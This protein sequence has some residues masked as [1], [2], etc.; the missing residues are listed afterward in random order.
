MSAPSPVPLD[1]RAVARVLIEIAMLLELKGDNPFKI[2]AYRNGADIVANAAEAV[3]G[4]DEAGL[5]AW[6]GIGKDLAGRIREIALTGDCAVRQDLLKEFP[7]TLLDVMRLQG[8]GPKTVAMLYRDLHIKSLEDLSEAAKAGRVRAL[9]GMGAKKEEL[10]LRALEE[11]QRHAGRHRLDQATEVAEALVAHLKQYAPAADVV[12]VGSVRRGAETSGDIDILATGAERSLTDAFVSFPGVERILGHGETKASILLRGGFQAD[13]RLV[14]PEE[15]GAALQYFTGSKAHNIALRDRALERGWK[16]NEYGL[17]D[18]QDQPIAGST[19]ED[20]YQALGLAWIPPEMRENRGEIAAAAD[21]VL[22]ALVEPGDL[23]G[24]LHMHTTESD[25]RESLEAIVSAARE[26]GLEYVAITDHTKSLAMTNGLD[27]DRTLAHAARIRALSRTLKG[28][29]V[30]AGI[31]CDILPDGS[32]DLADDCLAALD[33]VIASVH[34]ALQQDEAEITARLIRAIEHPSVDIIGHPTSR[35]LLRREASKVRIE[36]V[37]DAAAANGVALEINSQPYRL[38]LSDSHA[39]LARDRGVKLVISSDAHEIPALG[40]TRWGVL[41]ARRAW[42]SKD[43][44]L[45]TRPV[46]AFRK[47]LRRQRAKRI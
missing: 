22:P 26:R 11:R 35:M 40:F 33:I 6:S 32:M 25:G 1:N 30:L 19:E 47:A 37:I 14:L 21:R 20:I 17:F 3:A 10:I 23:R 15:R 27:E 24:D 9:K 39:R 5:R 28:F 41:T 16:L 29:T 13:L 7:A 2:R 34:S 18:P 46:A 8:V 42:L 12:T 45:N 36:K 4:L 43:D 44:V 38:D 31:E